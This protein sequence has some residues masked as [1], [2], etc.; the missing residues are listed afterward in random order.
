MTRTERIVCATRGTRLP[1]L[2]REHNIIHRYLEARS[3]GDEIHCVQFSRYS[4]LFDFDQTLLLHLWSK[5]NMPI[6]R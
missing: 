5:T 2:A 4:F 1:E 3:N 6:N